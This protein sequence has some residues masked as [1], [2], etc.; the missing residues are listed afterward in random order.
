MMKCSQCK[1]K[2]AEY[3]EGNLPAEVDE[4]I[5]VHLL[6]CESCR[7]A[8]EEEVV[9]YEAFKAA[10][11]IDDIKFES[12]TPKV[13]DTID[14]NKY[15]NG[16][17]HKKI[18]YMAPIAAALFICIAI[19]PIALNYINNGMGEAK[20]VA[21]NARSE[22]S[23]PKLR[24]RINQDE[25]QNYSAETPAEASQNDESNPM[26]GNVQDSGKVNY[27]DLYTMTAVTNPSIEA[28]TEYISTEDGVYEATIAGKGQYAQEEGIGII[29]VK[30]NSNNVT[31]EVKLKD[32]EKQMSP[33][34]ISWYDDTHLIIVQGFAYGTLANGVD[35]VVMNVN[36]AQ[37]MLIATVEDS[38]RISYEHVY[39]DGSDLVI[40]LKRYT[41]EIMNEFVNE[42][43][44][45]KDYNL[46]DVIK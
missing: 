4:E 30:N 26:V 46:G 6:T 44:R 31:F 9:E 42:E 39:R 3:I 35:I 25:E 21:D 41:D 5:R 11:S 29:Y 22:Q 37:Q 10:F 28:N 7:E 16:S 8:Y 27:V 23:S 34:S 40:E 45:I 24:N 1:E 12:I 13:M 33:L 32:R 20:G 38:S 2:L 36:N 14:K 18:K 19:S 17:K 43:R 15:A